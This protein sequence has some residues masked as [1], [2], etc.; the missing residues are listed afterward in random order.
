MYQQYFGFVSLPFRVTPDPRV[1]YSNSIYQ[2]AFA[3]LRYGIEARKGFIVITGEVGT[4]KT[5]LLKMFMRSAEPAL[6]TAYVFYPKLSFTELL[7][8]I[9]HDLGIPASAGDNLTLIHRLNDYLIRQYENGQI[10]A[11]LLDEA[12]DLSRELLEQLR[13]LSN[14]ETDDDK[15]IQIV[16]MGQPELEQRLEQP[17]LRQLKQR[18]TLRC[19]LA[20]LKAVEIR[21]FIDLRLKTAGY[22]GP[23]LFD[24]AAVERITLYSAGIPRLINVICDNALLLT[25]ALS[26]NKVSAELIEEAARDLKLAAPSPT[27]THATTTDSSISRRHDSARVKKTPG[28]VSSRPEQAAERQARRARAGLAVGASLA[29]AILVGGSVVLSGSQGRD[30]LSHLT[31]GGMNFINVQAEKLKPANPMPSA[32]TQ[33]SPPWVAYSDRNPKVE[34]GQPHQA[35]QLSTVKD[36]GPNGETSNNSNN[37]QTAVPSPE[38]ASDSK[39]NGAPA[40]K[41]NKPA[42]SG[43]TKDRSTKAQKP[44]SARPIPGES[45]EPKPKPAE[46]PPSSRNEPAQID[47]QKMVKKEQQFSQGVFEVID[48]CLVFDKP[49]QQAAVITTLPP[50][51]WVR[52]EK[53]AGSYLLISSLNDPAVRGY[54]ALEDAS[55]ERI[56]N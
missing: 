29:L 42:E 21:N 10:V 27:Q 41:K 20:P 37:V 52:V 44:A 3:T 11:L 48:N 31:S 51:T 4:G 15:L 14:L 55:L 34:W 45:G 43:A 26:K 36:S 13:L 32:F 16:L 33:N 28:W 35:G 30:Y 19:R 46:P 1:F 49:Q 17:E 50:L 25:Y 5:T 9:L 18:V 12:Q 22:E 24:Q 38:N 39:E 8:F 6:H 54:V 7:R 56:G 47:A 2:E 53:K 23:E 40:Q